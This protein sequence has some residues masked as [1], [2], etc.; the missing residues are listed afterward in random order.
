MAT[1]RLLTCVLIILHG[2]ELK[3][4]YHGSAAVVAQ[5]SAKQWE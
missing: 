5:L 1:A 4:T 3:E 2:K